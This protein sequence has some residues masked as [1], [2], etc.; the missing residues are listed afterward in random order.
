MKARVEATE[1][2]VAELKIQLEALQNKAHQDKDAIITEFKSSKEYDDA[3]DNA[4][5]LEIE[6]CWIIAEKHIK[7]NPMANWDSFVTEFQA[8]K[9]AIEEGKG[10][11][12]PYDDPSPSF[13][14][15]PIDQ[16]GGDQD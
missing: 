4:G 6:R 9:A 14:P 7:T 8:A 11:P 2:E 1:K 10:E 12:E 13:L 16:H 3:I 15:G 5:G